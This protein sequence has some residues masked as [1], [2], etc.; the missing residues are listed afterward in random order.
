[1]ATAAATAAATALPTQGL[2]ADS[3][4]PDTEGKAHLF[5]IMYLVFKSI[6]ITN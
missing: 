1:M 3:E 6:F 5:I 4:P 2:A